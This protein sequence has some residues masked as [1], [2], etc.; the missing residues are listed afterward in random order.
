[1][2]PTIILVENWANVSE[3]CKRWM[4]RLVVFTCLLTII[5]A[6]PVKHR[7][8]IDF[9]QELGPLYDSFAKLQTDLKVMYLKELAAASP[10]ERPKI[11]E[12]WKEIMRQHVPVH[13]PGSSEQFKRAWR[14]DDEME[15]DSFSM[16][17]L[18]KTH[19]YDSDGFLSADEIRALYYSELERAY[20]DHT[21]AEEKTRQLMDTEMLGSI[22]KRVD[23]DKD[24][25]ISFKEFVE[26]QPSPDD[27][28]EWTDE[29][30]LPD[31]EHA[32]DDKLI[33]E[34]VRKDLE[35]H[36]NDTASEQLMHEISGMKVLKEM[37]PTDPFT[38]HKP[39]H[40]AVPQPAVPASQTATT[41]SPPP[42]TKP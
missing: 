15:D 35:Q 41:P 2:C 4:A 7:N 17:S 39:H 37:K 30:D 29:D 5:C 36:P 19:D 38:V 32:K 21:D 42:A 14:E 10:E 8:A 20:P 31:L 26:Y 11:H 23:K 24:G 28:Y 13:S 18:F 6:P 9:K 25:K 22:L 16:A 12:R 33:I 1:M 3:L 34:A 27:S 40:D